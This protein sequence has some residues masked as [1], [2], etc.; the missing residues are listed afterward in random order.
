M[1]HKLN[2]PLS[3]PL[4]SPMSETPLESQRHEE[5]LKTNRSIDTLQRILEKKEKLEWE[6]NQ[7]LKNKI[8]R[9]KS[10]NKKLQEELFT[11]SEM[12]RER[13]ETI[14]QYEAEVSRSQ[15]ELTASNKK[16]ND[17]RMRQEN[18]KKLRHELHEV[19]EEMKRKLYAKR[20]KYKEAL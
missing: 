18:V 10:R 16:I 3:K 17:Q 8:Q 13:D 1:Y 15:R 12:L 2:V 9:L 6:S 14:A 5:I 4:K 11:M 7:A 20:A 19:V